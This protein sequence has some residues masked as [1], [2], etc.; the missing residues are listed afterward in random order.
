MN[1]DTIEVAPKPEAVDVDSFLDD[2]FG[3]DEPIPTGEGL[4][5]TEARKLLISEMNTLI[6]VGNLIRLR[7]TGG[8]A[9]LVRHFK[10]LKNINEAVFMARQRG[11]YDELLR[12]SGF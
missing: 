8:R 4:T 5:T 7:K 6:Q 11:G 12:N 2:I 9:P 1:N 3:E 10:G